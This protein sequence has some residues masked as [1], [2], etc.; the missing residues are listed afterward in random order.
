[1][2]VTAAQPRELAYVVVGGHQAAGTLT[3]AYREEW[4]LAETLRF[5]VNYLRLFAADPTERMARRTRRP[6]GRR[7]RAAV[8]GETTPTFTRKGLATRARIVNGAAHLMFERACTRPALMMSAEWPVSAVHS[9]P[10]TSEI[11]AISFAKS[12][13]RARKTLSTCT[14]SR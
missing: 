12:L 14:L 9:S 5:V 13:P 8:D 4:P 3:Y 7:V 2:L 11:S 10:T 1:M 6:R